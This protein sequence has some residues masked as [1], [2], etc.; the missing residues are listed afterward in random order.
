[1]FC[2]REIFTGHFE[3]ILGILKWR[4][5]GYAATGYRTFQQ[6]AGTFFLSLRLTLIHPQEHIITLL[7]LQPSGWVTTC[8]S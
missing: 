7:R 2:R 4:V 5:A 8:S 1:M 3:S 6:T